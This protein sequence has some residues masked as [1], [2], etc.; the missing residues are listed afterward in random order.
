MVRIR[1]T[2]QNR[3]WQEPFRARAASPPSSDAFGTRWLSR[4]G[5]SEGKCWGE[6]EDATLCSSI[7]LSRCANRSKRTG[8]VHPSPSAL[9]DEGLRRRHPVPHP[10]SALRP[11]WDSAHCNRPL[12]EKRVMG[13]ICNSFSVMTVCNPPL[14]EYFGDSPG[15]WGYMRPYIETLGTQAPI[16]TPVQCPWEA[17]LT[18]LL[19]SQVETL[20]TLFSFPRWINLPKRASS[21]TL[22]CALCLVSID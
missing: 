8:E 19:P 9:R 22:H 15:A 2:F 10:H 21:N 6:G 3:V 13:P 12:T 5:P 17:G 18:E 7:R 1:F 20:F 16:N 11:T 4:T 14:W